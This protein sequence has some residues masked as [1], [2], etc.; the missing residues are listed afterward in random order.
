MLCRILTCCCWREIQTSPISRSFLLCAYILTIPVQ[1]SMYCNNQSIECERSVIGGCPSLGWIA[2][3]A[4]NLCRPTDYSILNQHTTSKDGAR[5]AE[6]NLP[7]QLWPIYQFCPWLLAL[8]APT[9]CTALEVRSCTSLVATV[10]GG[11]QENESNAGQCIYLHP[12]NWQPRPHFWVQGPEQFFCT[13]EPHV[14][15]DDNICHRCSPQDA[16]CKYH[17][18]TK[19]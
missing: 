18:A 19:E 6:C 3:A 17:Q 14:P 5:G 9:L 2:L 7:I 4:E 13:S 10:A 8:A 16:A 1:L 12:P 15:L 11:V